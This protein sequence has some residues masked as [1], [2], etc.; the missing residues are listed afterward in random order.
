MRLWKHSA[1]IDCCMHCL[2]CPHF[3]EKCFFR[4]ASCNMYSMF[5]QHWILWCDWI[6]CECASNGDDD[7]DND[8]GGSN[9]RHWSNGM[10]FV[11]KK[12]N[13]LIVFLCLPVVSYHGQMKHKYSLCQTTELSF[14]K[15]FYEMAISF[16]YLYSK[17]MR[18]FSWLHVAECW[19]Q[20]WP[21]GP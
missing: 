8:S 11:S 1:L 16:E 18:H 3:H 5:H 2:Q 4:R 15:T 6:V 13:Y 14:S 20:S 10:K 7:D 9:E 17:P 21:V 12:N 19:L